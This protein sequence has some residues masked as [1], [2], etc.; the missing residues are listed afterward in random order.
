VASE[1][2]VLYDDN[3]LIAPTLYGIA[4]NDVGAILGISS[5]LILGAITEE[6]N[7]RNESLWDQ[8]TQAGTD[9]YLETF[10][11]LSHEDFLRGYEYA[12]QQGGELEK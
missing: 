2:P 1:D 5:N 12:A 10:G 11:S 7:D 9:L 8:F 4:A 6:Y 3:I